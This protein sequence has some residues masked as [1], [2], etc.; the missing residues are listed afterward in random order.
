MNTPHVQSRNLFKALLLVF[1]MLGS[2]GAGYLLRGFRQ[3]NDSAQQ[4]YE[5]RG[6]MRGLTNPLLD[7]EV[8]GYQHGRELRPFKQEIE[9]LVDRLILARDAERIS[10]YFRDLD[11]GPWFGIREEE[12][13]TGAS[14]LKAPAIMAALLQ[15]EDSPGFLA[16]TV[17]FEGYPGEASPGQYRPEQ[18]LVHGQIYTVDDLLRRAAAYSDNA[19]V[20]VLNQ[21]VS[22]E[23]TERV[24][25]ELDVPPFLADQPGARSISPRGYGHLFRVLYNASYLGRKLSERALDYFSKSSFR[26]GLEAGVPT[27]TVVAH[28]FGI[29]TIPGRT[30]TTQLHDCGVIYLPGRPYFLCVMTEG[31]DADSLAAVIRQISREVFV[32][33]D[34]QTGPFHGGGG[35]PAR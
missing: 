3:P 34:T 25:R 30:Q 26:A 12:R 17:Q 2:M 6:E 19:A 14:L 27:G 11:N 24:Y 33:I 1:L 18:R 28:K 31:S 16:R 20:G 9:A 35:A 32:A 7:C 23:Y 22:P 29:Y 13:F 15:A 21:I 10:L 4:S 5:I 8:A